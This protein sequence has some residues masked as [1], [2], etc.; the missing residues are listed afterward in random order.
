EW[1]DCLVGLRGLP[2]NEDAE[3]KPYPKSLPFDRKAGE[4]WRE[5]HDRFAPDAADGPAGLEEAAIKL[6]AYAARFAGVVQVIADPDAVRVD[7]ASLHAGIRLADWFYAEA[8]IVY[9]MLAR[10]PER[11][12]EPSLDA[13]DLL[14]RF[15]E[16]AGGVTTLREAKRHHRPLQGEGVGE[17]AR[18]ALVTEGVI[19]VRRGRPSGS[20]GRG[21][22][23]E[24]LCLATLTREQAVSSGFNVDG[25][26]PTGFGEPPEDGRSIDS[27]SDASEP[28][29]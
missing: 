19:E 27:L 3:G 24:L 2:M 29:A 1:R 12:P 10:G 17:A 21:P 14:L 28:S 23:P 20:A 25:F 7:L 22:K 9:A 6:R 18:D 15:I 13:G 4:L 8:K 16:D 11:K 5:H 26:P